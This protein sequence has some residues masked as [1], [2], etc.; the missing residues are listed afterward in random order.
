MGETIYPGYAVCFEPGCDFS[1]TYDDEGD[2]WHDLT[3]HQQET[4]HQDG[5]SGYNV[6]ETDDNGK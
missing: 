2:A 6:E 5:E 1:R 3:N 4:G